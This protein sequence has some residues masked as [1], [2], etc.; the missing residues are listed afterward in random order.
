MI[1]DKNKRIRE[2][3]E[4]ITYLVGQLIDAHLKSGVPDDW[5][6]YNIMEDI[7]DGM[8]RYQRTK[9]IETALSQLIAHDQHF[10]DTYVSN[11]LELKVLLA[12][13]KKALGG[14][15]VRGGSDSNGK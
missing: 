4:Q 13:G 1:C 5:S 3:E 10:L 8:A 6:N 15:D 11:R 7:R 14:D 9:E 12:Q 2:L